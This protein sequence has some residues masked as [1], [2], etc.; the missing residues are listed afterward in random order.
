MEPYGSFVYCNRDSDCRSPGLPFCLGNGVCGG[1]K[2]IIPCDS[3]KGGEDDDSCAK[4]G[5]NYKCVNMYCEGPPQIYSPWVE[6]C[7]ICKQ[8]SRYYS[9]YDNA[10]T[11]FCSPGCHRI[12]NLRNGKTKNV[13]L[14]RIDDHE[15]SDA[16]NG[17]IVN[18]TVSHHDKGCALLFKVCRSNDPERLLRLLRKLPNVNIADEGGRS[19]LSVAVYHSDV[20]VTGMLLKAEADV[21]FTGSDGVTPLMGAIECEDQTKV[22]FLVRN[23]AKILTKDNNGRIALHRTAANSN[24]KCAEYLL[25]KDPSSVN[26][27]DNCGITTLHMALGKVCIKI[28]LEKKLKIILKK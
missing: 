10:R 25:D 15:E 23:G 28:V 16:I 17:D 24:P 9:N 7:T 3:N 13:V 6:R 26:T 5:K 12:Y 8:F 27:A 21:N 19:L 22:K 14:I 1:F 11:L 18:K 2:L 20:I 4:L